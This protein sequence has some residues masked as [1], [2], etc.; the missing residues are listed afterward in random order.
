[1]DFPRA[2]TLL[3]GCPTPLALVSISG[4]MLATNAAWDARVGSGALDA[5][6]HEQDHAALAEARR[7]A[8][9]VEATTSL[10]VRLAR[11]GEG[12][13]ARLTFWR[14]DERSLWASAE[15]TRD[16]AEERKARIL[17]DCFRKM[18]AIVWSCDAEGKV[19]VS[20]GKGLALLG[21]APGAAVG[22][23]VFELYPTD[24]K[25]HA[26][27]K[28]ALA[29]ETFIQE[30]VTEK[31]HWRNV[32]T[33]LVDASGAVKG[34][35][36]LAVHDGED[37]QLSKKS[38]AITECVDRLPICI[39]A[40]DKKGTC[41][42]FEGA[43]GR[44]MGRTAAD[45][46][47]KNLFEIYRERPD[48]VGDMR[49]ALSGEAYVVE[50]PLRDTQLRMRYAPLR[51]PFGEVIGA[52][53]STEDATEELRFEAQ[54]RAQ[55]ELIASQKQAIAEL[56]TPI[57]E[58]WQ[59]VLAVPVVGTLDA[60]RAEQMLGALL[61][62]VVD[63]QASFAL[64]D[65]TGVETVDAATAQHLVRVASAVRLL[66]CEGIITGI[67]PSVAKTLVGIDVDLA[68]IRTL[69][70]FKDALRFCAGLRARGKR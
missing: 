13:R 8:F 19:L 63:K 39:W 40:F 22:K 2:E 38:K 41:T 58:V 65:L 15:V 55:L 4:E 44:Q 34:L 12:E 52:C 3:H 21:L 23:S 64:L 24:S 51:D 18:D 6:I 57:L 45:L 14:A 17:L 43:L 20:D 28:R 47:G 61:E 42:L 25:V 67:R 56:G 50:R 32:Y 31:A 59:D 53:A 62:A 37:L 46:V 26:I 9:G 69:Q 27:V 33:P 36:S 10:D 68:Q 7:A 16:E 54:L 1:M 35:Q 11:Q 66:G 5:R 49:R 29:G 60:A 30:D 48:L 70:S